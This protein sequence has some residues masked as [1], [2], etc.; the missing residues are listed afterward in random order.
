[1]QLK[2]KKCT[3]FG[4]GVSGS[5]ATKFLAKQG[6]TVSVINQGAPQTWKEYDQFKDFNLVDQS[7]PKAL[8]V[9]ERSEIVVLSP[10]IPRSHPLLLKAHS[11]GVPVISEI[12]LAFPFVQAE[13]V[14]AIT[15]SNGKT[16]TVTL[17]AKALEALNKKVFLGGNI[18]TPLCELAI[19]EQKVDYIVLELSSFQLESMID[20][21]ADVSAILNLTMNHGERYQNLE[22]YAFA[23][24]HI[25]DRQTE[26][27]TFIFD[28]SSEL[29][30]KWIQRLS[31][32]L[33]P[34]ELHD[35]TILKTEL[36]SRY[37]LSKLKLAG[38]HNLANLRVVDQ[39]L[40]VL[41]LPKTG[42]QKVIDT[43]SGVHHRV[44]F[45]EHQGPFVC[46]NDAKSTN[47]DATMAALK[48]MEGKPSP[49]WLVLGGQPRGQGEV[50]SKEV[51]NY[52]RDHVEMVLVIGAAQSFLQKELGNHVK[53]FLAE[54]LQGMAKQIKDK[55][56]AG[57]LLFSPAFPSFDQ[58]S[59][60]VDRGEKFK[61]AITGIES[62]P[63]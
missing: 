56:F 4:L 50:P 8:E 31:C 51:L 13:K 44:E 52:L 60:Y 34:L 63:L 11:Q 40:E 19:S 59:N 57:T 15:G 9:M 48:A 43:F 16:T 61:Q 20:F 27:D 49:L 45:V 3:V 1:M 14:L 22:D 26:M 30:Q 41:K 58:F 23:K 28:Q 35:S 29:L 32:Q 12:E 53:V 54:N 47:W 21:K 36:E 10:G 42:L 25:T 7:D 2:D 62:L 46:Y 33:C 18:G 55:K 17:L 6:A 37:D 24:F 38:A 39:F 5:S